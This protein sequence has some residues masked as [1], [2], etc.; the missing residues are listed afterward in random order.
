MV[1]YW[2]VPYRSVER[3]WMGILP[4]ALSLPFAP[5]HSSLNS[6]SPFSKTTTKDH[7][8]GRRTSGAYIKKREQQRRKPILAETLSSSMAGNN[9]AQARRTPC[10]QMEKQESIGSSR[11]SRDEESTT[12]SCSSNGE[13]VGQGGEGEEESPAPSFVIP[14]ETPILNCECF[15][16]VKYG[17]RIETVQKLN[18]NPV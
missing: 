14:E 4:M 1:L 7:Q 16:W 8:Q 10:R 9:R 5:I 2:D 17:L 6:P 3:E 18:L 13:G 15:F 12:T 11:G